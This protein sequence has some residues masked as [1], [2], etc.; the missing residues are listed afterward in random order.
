MTPSKIRRA[1]RVSQ[2][3]IKGD[4]GRVPYGKRPPLK[5]TSPKG[6]SPKGTPT[7][8]KRYKAE[9]VAPRKSNYAKGGKVRGT[10]C[11]TK[12][13]RPAKTY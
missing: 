13:T 9:P 8:G 7:K 4:T 6:T 2:G 5:G 12:G 11:A 3:K 10:G 1:G